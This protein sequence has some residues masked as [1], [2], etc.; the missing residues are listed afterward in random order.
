MKPTRPLELSTTAPAQP[1]NV[2][3]VMSVA[4][5]IVVVIALVGPTVN[6]DQVRSG[7]VR[8]TNRSRKQEEGREGVHLQM[9]GPETV[10]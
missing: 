9:V 5:S 3:N 6:D 4:A 2:P 7:Q 1:L 8:V 10:G